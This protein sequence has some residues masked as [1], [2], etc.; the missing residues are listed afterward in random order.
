[1]AG[2]RHLPATA[3]IDEIS[4][5]MDED[6][7]VVVN[8]FLAPDALA[9]FNDELTPHLVAQ[10]PAASGV[11]DLVAAFHGDRMRHLTGVAGISDVFVHDVLLH[12]LYKQ[13]GDHYLL[14]NCASYL[15]NL[16]HVLDRG[17]GSREQMLH[18]DHD[19]WPREMGSL[20]PTRMFVSLV[21]LSAYTADMGATRLVPGSHRWPIDRQPMPDEVVV[22]EMAPGSAV[23]YFGSTL[24]GA[25]ANTTDRYR[26]GMHISFCL[27]FLRTEENNLLSTPMERVR[28]M[29]RRA[30]ELLGFGV[31]DGMAKGEGFL[32]AVDNHNPI[33][34]IASGAL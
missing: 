21:A 3:N 13:V 19:V 2:L 18:R 27:G 34:L 28:N 25:G 12:P 22:A 30:Q 1:M 14:P 5:I 29:P 9:R 8:G 23:L 15:L 7:A 32:G 33:D 4:A 6:G 10:Q 11:N 26:R 20:F 17:P 24:H 31:H 16:G